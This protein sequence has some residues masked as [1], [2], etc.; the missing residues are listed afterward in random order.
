[1]S[2]LSWVASGNYAGY[3]ACSLLFSF[4]AFHQPSRLRPLLLFSALASGLLILAMAWL[5]PF[6]LVLWSRCLV[7]VAGAG[8]LIFGSTL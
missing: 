2:Q 7:G 6:I 5:P 1:F 3:L 4:G 8:M